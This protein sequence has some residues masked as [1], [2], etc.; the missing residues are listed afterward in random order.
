MEANYIDEQCTFIEKQKS[1]ELNYAP[2]VSTVPEYTGDNIICNE[3][4]KIAANRRD[5]STS[6]LSNGS[7]GDFSPASDD[8]RTYLPSRKRRYR[9]YL[10]TSRDSS[11]SSSSSSSSSSTSSDSSSTN[12]TVTSK[13]L[14]EQGNNLMPVIE[15]EVTASNTVTDT[16]LH[17][18]PSK[19]IL[20]QTL[21]I[22]RLA[23]MSLFL[24]SVPKREHVFKTKK[25]ASEDFTK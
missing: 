9:K 3:P 21:K 7:N 14:N 16:H 4:L 23:L 13:A 5:S 1:L 8:D 2:S 17:N 11:T 22:M 12:S 6:K 20:Y 25:K 10:A 15:L 24:L 19:I 18:T